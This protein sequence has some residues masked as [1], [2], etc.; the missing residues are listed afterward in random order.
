MISR[1]DAVVL[2][3]GGCLKG[4]AKG[5]PRCFPAGAPGEAVNKSLI[6][7]GPRLMVD[8]VLEALEACPE[9]ARIVLVGP[10]DFQEAYG[11]ERP[12]AGGRVPEERPDAG[13][14]VPEERPEAGGRKPEKELDAGGLMFAAPGD[15]VLGSLAA[16]DAA[17][18]GAACP[19]EDWVLCCTGDIPFL[20]AAAVTDF[21]G[22][23]RQRDADFYYPII[24]RQAAESRFPGV[25]RTYARLRDGVFTGGNL[26][27][28]RRAILKDALPKAEGFIRLRKRPVA[29]AR[30]VGFGFLFGYLFGR[31]SIEFAERRVSKL[32]GY[33]GAA[34]ISDYP[35]IGVDVDKVSDLALACRL[36]AP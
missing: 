20:T 4:E 27:L 7:I 6:R 10:P 8:Y 17:L 16:G 18:D 34:V 36:L 9:V 19:R 22:K 12:G 33:R 11:E 35:E 13:G 3:G 32:V 28:V 14:R 15:T 21:I 29:L 24:S 26:F 5:P 30:L 31:L 2:A 25:R 1:V 23:C